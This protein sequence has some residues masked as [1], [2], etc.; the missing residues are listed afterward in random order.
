MSTMR[1]L[2]SVVITLA[3]IVMVLLIQYHSPTHPTPFPCIVKFPDNIYQNR[4][5]LVVCPHPDDEYQGW[6][7]IGNDEI[8]VFL[9]LTQGEKTSYCNDIS[10]A[11][12]KRMRIN[13]TTSFLRG[14]LAKSYGLLIMDMGDKNLTRLQIEP[15][16]RSV[17]E[18]LRPT[19]IIVAAYYNQEPGCT[20]YR[21]RD[22]R[23]LNDTMRATKWEIPVYL[24]VPSCVS[25]GKQILYVDEMVHAR[26]WAAGGVGQTAYGWLRS[27]GWPAG[28]SDKDKISLFTRRQDFLVIE[29][30]EPLVRSP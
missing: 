11:E 7:A 27:G 4:M 19:K 24:R 17:V 12:C 26:A 9:L 30:R 2:F 5:V 8:P 28:E 18:K 6:A 1:V 3:L 16:L 29:P 23:A 21:H 20:I 13:S 15:M 14:M 22:H 25:S 10:I